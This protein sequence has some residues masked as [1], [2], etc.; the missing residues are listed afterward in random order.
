MLMHMLVPVYSALFVS[1]LDLFSFKL[2]ISLIDSFKA[3]CTDIC[4]FF[5]DSF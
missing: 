1:L 5:H 2:D 4:F 3:N